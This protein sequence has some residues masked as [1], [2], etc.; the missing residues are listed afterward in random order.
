MVA[1]LEA[2]AKEASEK[3][4]KKRKQVNAASARPTIKGRNLG[5]SGGILNALRPSKIKKL[6]QQVDDLIGKNDPTSDLKVLEILRI[7]YQCILDGEEDIKNV[8]KKL[9]G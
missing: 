6:G 4:E 3:T 5:R 2:A 8:L 1:E 9:A 7:A